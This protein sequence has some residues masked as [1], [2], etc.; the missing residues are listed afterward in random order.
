MDAAYLKTILHYSALTG[1]FTWR[2]TR[3][4]RGARTNARAGYLNGRGYRRIKVDQVSYP[5]HHMAWLYMTGEWRAG[6]IDHRNGRRDDD[7]W[8]NLRPATRTQNC[9]NRG[10]NKNNTT[11]AP[12]VTF[13]RGRFE[14]SLMLAGVKTYLGSYETLTEAAEAYQT[15]SVATRGVFARRGGVSLVA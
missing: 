6:D 9:A 15:A 7:T 4:G 11:G 14:A 1:H 3:G 2:V 10:I 5:A 13:R 12:G 8:A